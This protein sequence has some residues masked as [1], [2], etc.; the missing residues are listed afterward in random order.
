LRAVVD[1]AIVDGAREWVGET[2]GSGTSAMP[3]RTFG[4]FFS[5]E[6]GSGFFSRKKRERDCARF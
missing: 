5:D 2:K 4:R 6:R 1:V 3:P